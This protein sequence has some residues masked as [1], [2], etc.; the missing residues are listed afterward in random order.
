VTGGQRLLLDGE[1][2]ALDQLG[3][4]SF[5]RLQQRWP[6]RRRPTRSLLEQVPVM[7]FAFDLLASGNDDLTDRPMLSAARC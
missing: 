7:F 3:R 6:M 1:I 2:V 4:P 5:S